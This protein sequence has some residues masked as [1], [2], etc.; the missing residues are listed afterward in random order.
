MPNAFT[1]NNDSV[2][3]VFK[4]EGFL[5]GV[6]QFS[7]KIWSRWGELIFETNDPDF[8]WNGLIGN[9]QAPQG[10]YLYEVSLNHPRGAPEFYKGFVTLVR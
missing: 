2:N 5:R 3:D 9:Q 6:R 8:G 10:V 4:G 7:L 1:P